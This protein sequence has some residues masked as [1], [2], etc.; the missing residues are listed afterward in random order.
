MGVVASA[1][2][3]REDRVKRHAPKKKAK[4]KARRTGARGG[5]DNVQRQNME[6]DDNQDD[7]QETAKEREASRLAEGSG[8]RIPRNRAASYGRLENNRSASR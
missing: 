2:E 8:C 7:H 3:P 1:R 4:E 5:G 6:V